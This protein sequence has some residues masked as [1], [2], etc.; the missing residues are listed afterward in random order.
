MKIGLR[1]ASTTDD[2]EPTLR[3]VRGLSNYRSSDDVDTICKFVGSD[4]HSSTAACRQSGVSQSL[5]AC[6]A[7]SLP[8]HIIKSIQTCSVIFTTSQ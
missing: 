2:L 3:D 8:H 6:A 7:E 4:M 1:K 5:A